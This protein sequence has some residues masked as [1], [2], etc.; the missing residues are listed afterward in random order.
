M[1]V[2]IFLSNTISSYPAGYLISIITNQSD[3]WQIYIHPT[4]LLNIIISTMSIIL[5]SIRYVS[6]VVEGQTKGQ[7][8]QEV[9][10]RG[11]P[12]ANDRGYLW[13]AC[14]KSKY[15]KN[16]NTQQRFHF[17]IGLAKMNY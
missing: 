14:Y 13:Y 12:V 10:Y 9:N 16:T 8:T 3:I 4:L 2:K 6:V 11:Y 5:P 15:T 1:K 7:H 17:L